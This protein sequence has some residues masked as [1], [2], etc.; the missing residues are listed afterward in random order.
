MGEK[1]ICVYTCITG[2]YDD[3]QPVEKEEG[4]DYICFT[5]NQR[6]KSD[7]WTIIYIENKNIRSSC[8]K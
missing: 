5:N 2:S 3:L 6:L 8:N 4:I 1:K 7:F